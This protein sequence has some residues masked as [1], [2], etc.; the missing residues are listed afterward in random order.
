[1]T[2]GWRGAWPPG[3]ATQLSVPGAEKG[4]EPG[5]LRAGGDLVPMENTPSG[6]ELDI[7]PF[8]KGKINLE[9]EM[10]EFSLGQF[11]A[12]VEFDG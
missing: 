11:H 5:H 8:F 2:S 10:E 4:Q 1:M 9:V 12:G 7:S 6:K 3:W